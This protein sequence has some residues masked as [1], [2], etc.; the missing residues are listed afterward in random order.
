M[1]AQLR[2]DLWIQ[3]KKKF[4]LPRFPQNVTQK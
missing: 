3:Q 4:V 2:D 1:E